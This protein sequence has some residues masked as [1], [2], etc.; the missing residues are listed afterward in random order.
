MPNAGEFIR[1][2]DVATQ[3]CR[4]TRTTVLSCADNTLVTVGFDSEVDDLYGMHSN[5]VNNSRITFA[6]AGWYHV[7]WQGQIALAADYIYVRYLIDLNGSTTISQEQ[8]AGTTANVSQKGGTS[9]VYWFDAGDYIEAKVDQ[10]NTA[11]TAR[12]LG[13]SGDW[14]P[15]FYAVRIGS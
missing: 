6:V 15:T 1:A 11:N 4:V 2:S 9:T 13:L 14:S 7:G 12:D 3:A 8:N 5:T 10:N